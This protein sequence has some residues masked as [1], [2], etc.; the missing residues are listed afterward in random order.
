ML[1]SLLPV[2]IA[3]IL[4]AIIIFLVY[5]FAGKK[6]GKITSFVLGIIFLV[7]LAFALFGAPASKIDDTATSVGEKAISQVVEE[8]YP[9]AQYSVNGQAVKSSGET[10]NEYRVKITA[11]YNETSYTKFNKDVCIRLGD[12]SAS[13]ITTISKGGLSPQQGKGGVCR[14]WLALE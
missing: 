5:Y 8:A 2:A 1:I 10:R 6:A 14:Y 13:L 3:L 7:A 12:S 11:E 4:F 9:G